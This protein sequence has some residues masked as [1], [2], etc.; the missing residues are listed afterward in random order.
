MEHKNR[1]KNFRRFLQFINVIFSPQE[2]RFLD[3]R[4]IL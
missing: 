2:A 3:L 1:R 4:V